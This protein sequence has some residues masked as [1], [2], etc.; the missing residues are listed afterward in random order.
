[1]KSRCLAIGCGVAAMLMVG[2][3]LAAPKEQEPEMSG[4]LVAHYFQ[5]PQNWNGVW[6]EELNEPTGS[7][8]DWTFTTY[9]YSRVEPLVN[10]KFIRQGWFSV[11]WVG[12]LDTRPG[13]PGQSEKSD[14]PGKDEGEEPAEASYLFEIWADDG[15][16]LIIDDRTIIDSWQACWEDSPAAVRKAPAVRLSEGRHRVVIEYFQGQ[17]LAKQDADPI[18]VYWSSAERKIPRQVIPAAHWCHD[19]ADLQKSGR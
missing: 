4:G 12:Y 7:P 13:A 10:H 6:P 14:K 16:R 19:A 11:R 8:L 3:L 17:S 5:D 2:T 15:C 18:K 1:M 9:A